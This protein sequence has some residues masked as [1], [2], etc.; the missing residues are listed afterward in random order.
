[1]YRQAPRLSI[2]TPS[3]N[4]ANFI[5]DAIRSVSS[6]DYSAHE[7]IVVDGGSTDG[8]YQVLAQFDGIKVIGGPDRGMYDAINKGIGIARGDI[9][10]ILNSDDMYEPN[11][12]GD[13]V[14]AFQEDLST[15]ALMGGASFFLSSGAGLK[16]VVASYPAIPEGDLLTWL[17]TVGGLFNAWFFRRSLFD[18][19][20]RLDSTYRFA[21]D[22]E[23]LIRLAIS[24]MKYRC[25][26]KRVYLYRRHRGSYTMGGQEQWSIAAGEEDLRIA[27]SY[28]GGSSLPAGLSRKL[29]KWHTLRSA[30]LATAC[31][32][33]VAFGRVAHYSLQGW[34]KDVL[35]PW[36][37]MRSLVAEFVGNARLES[38]RSGE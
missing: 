33:R 6:Q 1:M 3:Y 19:L 17:T 30:E 36:V 14:Q 35:W 34:R 21:A 12:F 4:R 23:F 2:I 22:R 9:V 27:A 5:S 37:L 13:V 15:V 18:S 10:G 8:T 32:R 31:I 11:V 24:G 29:R 28:M 38:T 26:A 16:E 20:G 25:L 7:H